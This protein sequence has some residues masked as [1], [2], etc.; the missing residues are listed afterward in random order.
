M[1]RPWDV[2]RADARSAEGADWG[3]VGT[4]GEKNGFLFNTQKAGQSVSQ[5]R[6]IANLTFPNHKYTP[7][8]ASECSKHSSITTFVPFNLGLPVFGVR[9]GFPAA[10]IAAMPMPK[11]S[12]HEHYAAP[13]R[14]HDVGLPF[15]VIRLRSK[16]AAETVQHRS[17][18]LLWPRVAALDGP[19]TRTALKRSKIVCHYLSRCFWAGRSI[20]SRRNCG[21]LKNRRQ[22][23]L[24][25]PADDGNAYPV[26]KSE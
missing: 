21:I 10:S 7:S 22:Y 20:R 11:T 18:N 2:S 19:H 15:Q 12:M 6:R 13:R 1:G 14:H 25:Y 9:G 17:Y 26:S 16:A 24:I 23:V 3:S 4:S 5:L 8:V